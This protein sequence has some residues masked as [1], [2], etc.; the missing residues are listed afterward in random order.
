MTFVT[1]IRLRHRLRLG[2]ALLPLAAVPQLL[3]A[4]AP[5]PAANDTL[6]FTNDEQLTGELLQADSAGITFR[7]PSAGDLKVPW[8]HIKDLKSN[9]SFA[10]IPKNQKLTR[11]GV[12]AAIPRGPVEVENKAV[13]IGG[14]KSVPTGEVDQV[15]TES[16]FD[17]AV[18]HSPGFFGGWT[19]SASA[20]VSLVRA[21]QNATTFT[22]NIS[23]VRAIPS[24]DWLPPRNRTFFLYNQAY[25]S[26]SQVDFPTIKTNIFH[27]EA[28][29]DEYLS[30][31]FYV[32]GNIAFDHNFSQGLDL[33]QQYGGGIGYTVIKSAL[34]E[35]DVK[36]DLHYEKQT[37]FLPVQT[38]NLI[39]S[40]FGETYLRHLPHTI[41]LTQFGSISPA[42]NNTSAY[43]A[44][45]GADLA[46]PVFRGIAFNVGATDDYLNN[47]SFP[48]NKNSSTFTTGLTY[49]FQQ[50]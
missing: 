45:V 20:G 15:I 12:S 42:W 6:I 16:A 25:G 34:Q 2:A 13:E 44:H 32:L 18:N 3:I 10:V 11:K 49:S 14:G 31:R 8:D 38:F 22:G 21:T 30:R 50:K 43:S 1:K 19:G 17:K 24:V 36:A 26:T 9:K 4:Q 28:E 23:L 39:G 27:A 5:K 46:F 40:T 29:R 37:F 47:A 41:L 33:Q 7:S 48:S 35:L